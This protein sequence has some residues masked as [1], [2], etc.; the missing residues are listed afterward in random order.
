MPIFSFEKIKNADT[1]LGP[2]MKSTG[3]VLGV[4]KKY[5]NAILKAFIASG[6]NISTS[7]SILITVRDKDKEEMLPIA[8]KFYDKGFEIYATSGTARFLSSNGIKANVV[9][10]I[11]EGKNSIIDLIQSGKINFVINTPTK[12]KEANRDGFK[13]RRTAV[14]CK[15]PCFTSLDTVNALYD[16]IEDEVKEEDLDVINIVEI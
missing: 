15:I 6:I 12:G 10:K 16:A 14:E 2:E 11:W 13:I 5:H 7:G 4:D 3:E 1:S 9:E 8:R